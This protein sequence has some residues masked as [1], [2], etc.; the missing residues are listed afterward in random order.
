MSPNTSQR[1]QRY[2][3]RALVALAITITWSTVWFWRSDITS[4]VYNSAPDHPAPPVLTSPDHPD[5]PQNEGGE[6]DPPA[7]PTTATGTEQPPSPPPPS[8][9]SADFLPPEYLTLPEDQQQCEDIFGNSYIRNIAGT[10]QE[11][12]AAGSPS[13]LHCFFGQR[14]RN[15]WVPWERDPL[16]LAQ[17]VRFA[18]SSGASAF[19]PGYSGA[20]FEM[21]CEAQNF[22]RDLMGDY[23]GGTG[24]GNTFKTWKFMSEQQDGSSTGM[25]GCSKENSTDDWIVL[26][27]REISDQ[28]NI[29]HQLMQISQAR[30]TIDALRTA[31]N[32]DTGRPWLSAADAARVQVVLDDDRHHALED[33]WRIAGGGG[34]PIRASD[35][36]PGTCYGNVIVPM[37][38]SSS[39]F[40]SALI[41]DLRQDCRG[42]QTLLD[43]FV[44]RVLAHYGVEPRAPSEIH[45]YP[46]ITIVDRAENRK[47][48]NLDARVDAL[49]VRHPS[50]RISVVDFAALTF[51]EQ[52]RLVQDTDV[53]VGHHG[54][55]MTH[56]LFMAPGAAAVEV[57]P[58]YFLQRGFR[59]LGRMR[60]LAYFTGRGMWEEEYRNVTRGEPLPEGW[61]PPR[62]HEGWKEREWAYM[63]DEDF[64][65]LVDAAVRS[66]LNRL[67][68]DERAV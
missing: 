48:I 68:D 2:S 34:A 37:P 10:V 27:R 44:A 33:L 15:R 3:H 32:P 40:W 64:L 22:D 13:E 12:C 49:R 56:T 63:L 9:A 46:T 8:P 61:S 57:L 51:A 39:P 31:I 41:G 25:S 30:H 18:P 7:E 29:W 6:Q 16:C 4:N 59:A 67:N 17:G 45:E 11:S 38:G 19:S 5:T 42:R 65:G 35:L 54:A 52:L 14:L 26:V 21:Q 66:Q 60:G 58:P 36:A 23:W 53:L 24:V 47:F 55:A 20:E 43:T 62:E 50:S 1:S 28:H